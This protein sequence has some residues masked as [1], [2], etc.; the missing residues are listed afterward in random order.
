MSSFQT[1]DISSGTPGWS[2]LVSRA[3]AEA[4]R[5]YREERWVFLASAAGVA[6]GLTLTVYALINGRYIPPEGDLKKPISFNVALGIFTA[7]QAL[8]LPYSNLKARGRARWRRWSIGALLFAFA[9]ETT[10]QLRGLDPR[11]SRYGTAFD[12]VLGGLFF[13]SALV[14]MALFV[15]LVGSVL[16]RRRSQTSDLISVSLYYAL[17]AAAVGFGAGFW[18][19]AIGGPRI[20]D[21]NVL[22]LHA[23]GFHGLQAIPLVALLFAWTETPWPVARSWTHIAGVAWLG[24]T[25]AVA[26]Q[27]ARGVPLFDPS[28]ALWMASV[29]ILAYV[30]ALGRGVT[31]GKTSAAGDVVTV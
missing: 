28:P 10:Q 4:G 2:G 8:M 17:A 24:A 14:V 26:L 31:A 1:L 22:P 6:L 23:L 13:L 9:V 30:V 3:L 27:T 12:D 15:V 20:G 19:S 7:T 25:F 11:F 29:F 16:R 5:T 18:M 21:A